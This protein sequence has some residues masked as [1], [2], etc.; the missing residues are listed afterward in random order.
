M[1]LGTGPTLW[2]ASQVLVGGVVLQSGFTSICRVLSSHFGCKGSCPCCIPRC[3][4]FCDLFDNLNAAGQ[5]RCPVYVMHSKSDEVIVISNEIAKILSG[6]I[7]WVC[8]GSMFKNHVFQIIPFEHA[9]H[10][11][12]ALRA[13]LYQP[14]I[15]NVWNVSRCH[16]SRN[17]SIHVLRGR[18]TTSFPWTNLNM[19]KN[20]RVSLITL[21]NGTSKAI[22][23]RNKK[24]LQTRPQGSQ[25]SVIQI[26]LARAHL[27]TALLSSLSHPDIV[28]MQSSKK[29][30]F[31]A[32]HQ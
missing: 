9:E 16:P 8:C 17:D 25:S 6:G 14:Y 4:E 23:L 30:S 28:T 20:W 12:D 21:L 32:H 5:I 24:V 1:S 11:M 13:N 19:P 3:S 7:I 18:N 26:A 29:G 2:L 27:M 31:M 15:V 22:N 10:M